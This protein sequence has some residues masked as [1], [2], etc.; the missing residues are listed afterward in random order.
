MHEVLSWPWHLEHVHQVIDLPWLPSAVVVI[1][2][3]AIIQGLTGF[4]SGLL[5][6]GLLLH[7]VDARVA[8]PCL[9]VAALGIIGAVLVKCHKNFNLQL[10]IWA[11][12]PLIFLTPVGAWLLNVLPEAPV[13]FAIGAILIAVSAGYLIRTA[14]TRKKQP[15]EPQP[16]TKGPDCMNFSKPTMC[17]LGE[18]SGVLG[19]ATAIPGPLLAAYLIRLGASRETFKV[20]LNGIFLASTLIRMASY[21]HEGML[22]WKYFGAGLILAPVGW[23]GTIVGFKLDRYVSAKKFVLGINLFLIALGAWLIYTGRAILN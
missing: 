14:P 2:F 12:V 8:V 17:V 11:G 22:P 20:T 15:A 1:F 16:K 7:Y 3:S 10:L 4:A 5:S 13:K 18:L 21:A 23:F 6:V 19:G 9:S